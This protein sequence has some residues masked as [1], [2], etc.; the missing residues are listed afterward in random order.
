MYNLNKEKS[1]R[2]QPSNVQLDEMTSLSETFY[3]MQER[4]EGYVEE[5]TAPADS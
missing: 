2:L 3:E 5:V 4:I 1:V